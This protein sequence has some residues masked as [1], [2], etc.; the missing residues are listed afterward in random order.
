M[1]TVL[2]HIKKLYVVL[3]GAEE[4]VYNENTGR[5]YYSDDDTG[6]YYCNARYYS[7]KWRR[8]I[9]PATSTINPSVVNGLNT[10]AYSNNN[11]IRI[12]YSHYSTDDRM[13][14]ITI[15]S[16]SQPSSSNGTYANASN[17]FGGL[18]AFSN[19]FALFDQ[20][21]GYLSGG[22]D[23][24]LAY[25]GPEGFGIK[26]LGK[27]SNALS[28]FGKGM[29]IAGSI[30]S[31]GSSVYNNF[32]NANY[33]A[34]EAFAATALDAAYYTAKGVGTYLAGT[35]VGNA[36]VSLGIAA[37]GA[38]IAYCGVSFLTAFAISGGVAVLA[39][40]AG[41]VAIYYLGVGVDLLYEELKEWIF[42]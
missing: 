30:L 23:A 8:F 22:L 40:I 2:V 37:G 20:W 13:H 34:G 35:A 6:L 19:A 29:L 17:I 9:S 38:S 25:W 10:Y 3:D 7:P 11:P 26:F 15:H 5:S 16:G 32:T 31:W 24:G 41:A 4:N 42:E 21:S 33:T 36:A 1:R 39:G 12:A 27:Y 14:N 28:K 18:Y